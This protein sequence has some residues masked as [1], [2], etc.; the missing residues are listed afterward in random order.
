VLKHVNITQF[1]TYEMWEKAVKQ[2][3]F[4]LEY[5]HPVFLTPELYTQAFENTVYVL[6]H[7][8]ITQFQTYKMW[9]KAVKQDGFLLEYCHPVFLCEELYDLAVEKSG[10]S[11]LKYI[12]LNS[13]NE[14]WAEVA[15]RNP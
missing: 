2:D 5:C 7:V 8:N 10:K 12:P 1:Q 4:L 14:T 11:V 3:G 9:E 15:A 6:K 13:R